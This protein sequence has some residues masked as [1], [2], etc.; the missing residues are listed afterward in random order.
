MQGRFS[1]T[2]PYQRPESTGNRAFT[3]PLPRLDLPAESTRPA[4]I[5]WNGAAPSSQQEGAERLR[6]A[7]AAALAAQASG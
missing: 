3:L 2:I 6:S 4:V 1:G 5:E 7:A